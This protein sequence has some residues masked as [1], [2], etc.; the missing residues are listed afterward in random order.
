MNSRLYFVRKI[1]KNSIVGDDHG[2]LDDNKKVKLVKIVQY[3]DP[4]RRE[5][6]NNPWF[7]NENYKNTYYN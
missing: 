5:Y 7:A 3:K 1:S 2:Y 6:K 4:Y